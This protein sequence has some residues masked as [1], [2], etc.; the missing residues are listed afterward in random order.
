MKILPIF[1]AIAVLATSCAAAKPPMYAFDYAPPNRVAWNQTYAEGR[2]T[3]S[4]QCVFTDERTD[5]QVKVYRDPFH[6]PT[7]ADALRAYRVVLSRRGLDVADSVSK[8]GADDAARFEIAD[9]SHRLKGE[10]IGLRVPSDRRSVVLIG[11]WPEEHDGA[12]RADMRALAA[13]MFI[14]PVE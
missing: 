8:L 5:T 11:M 6:S 3:S 4:L 1:F 13:N 14:R 9:P 10:V 7:P 12:A 2:E